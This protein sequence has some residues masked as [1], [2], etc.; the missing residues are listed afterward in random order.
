[1][2]TKEQAAKEL[3]NWSIGNEPV[4]SAFL[5]GVVFAERWIDVN[6]ELP[7]TQGNYIVQYISAQFVTDD[8]DK[9]YFNGKYFETEQSVK[10][11]RPLYKK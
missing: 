10:Y 11:W 8:W 5:E 7:E 4:K 3:I 2:K 6:D 9:C 1:M